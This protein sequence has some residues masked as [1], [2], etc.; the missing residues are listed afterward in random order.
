MFMAKSFN[1]GLFIPGKIWGQG[2]WVVLTP[3]SSHLEFQMR[4]R[5]LRRFFGPWRMDRAMVREVYVSKPRALDP[6]LR[7]NFLGE[8]SM[9]WTFMTETPQDIL[10]CVEQLG[11]P[12]RSG[13]L[14][15]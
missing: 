7:V 13:E 5:W 10:R 6:S 8:D 9:P 14:Q 2:P 4:F 1:G 15:G 12:V 3:T 11:Y